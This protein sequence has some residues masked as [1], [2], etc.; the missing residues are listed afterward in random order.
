M[1]DT[2]NR[3]RDRSFEREGEMS[4][5]VV[6]CRTDTSLWYALRERRWVNAMETWGRGGGGRVL[7]CLCLCLI[8]HMPS[9]GNPNDFLDNRGD[10]LGI[11]RTATSAIVAVCAARI[12][13]FWRKSTPKSTRKIRSIRGGRV[14]R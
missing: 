8:S 2:E 7:S 12:L 5:I 4:A 9:D 3:I 10:N 13:L 6:P 14:L 1:I 11:P